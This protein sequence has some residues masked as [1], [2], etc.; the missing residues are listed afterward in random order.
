MK[1]HSYP[2]YY[3]AIAVT[4]G[5]DARTS[6]GSFAGIYT[7]LDDPE[8]FDWVQ[9]VAFGVEES[10]GKNNEADFGEKWN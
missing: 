10:S 9:K 6:C 7:R 8:V 3:E 4:K 2:E 5:G 1:Y